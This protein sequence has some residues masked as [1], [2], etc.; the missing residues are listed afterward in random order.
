M[1]T[2]I[3]AL[4]GVPIEFILFATVLACVAVFHHHSLRVALNGLALITVY[5]IAFSSFHG[6]P[7]VA[8]LVAYWRASGCLS[9]TCCS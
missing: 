5:K 2:T 1:H 9:S 7:G 3:P 4:A 8:G 6:N